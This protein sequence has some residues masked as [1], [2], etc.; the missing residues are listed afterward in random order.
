M[1]ECYDMSIRLLNTVEA[2]V[3]VVVVG[4]VWWGDTGEKEDES[5][6]TPNIPQSMYSQVWV[7]PIFSMD[8]FFFFCAFWLN[9]IPP[10]ANTDLYIRI[11]ETDYKNHAMFQL[12]MDHV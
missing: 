11:C 5:W 6:L 10:M 2:A 4:S 7:L 9:Y 8:F 1:G 12:P 3:V